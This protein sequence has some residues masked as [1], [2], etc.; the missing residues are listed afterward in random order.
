MQYLNTCRRELY[1][2]FS[3]T[4]FYAFYL[5]LVRVLVVSS[6]GKSFRSFVYVTI[7]CVGAGIT[8]LAPISDGLD[9]Y[10]FLSKDGNDAFYESRDGRRGVYFPPELALFFIYN[11]I[12]VLCPICALNW[13]VNNYVSRKGKGIKTSNE[14]T[15]MII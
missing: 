2:S 8:T 6:Y 15:I 9:P 13:R 10:N 7:Y 11:M 4:L 12:K 5:Y 14:S 3:C 1:P